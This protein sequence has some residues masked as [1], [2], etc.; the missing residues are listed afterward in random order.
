MPCSAK[1]SKRRRANANAQ[2]DRGD[3]QMAPAGTLK[4]TATTDREIVVQRAFNAPRQLV[5]DAHTKPELLKR[6]LGVHNGW[7]LDV[8]EVDLRVGGTFRYVWRGPNGE[9]MGMRGVYREIV[10][11]SRIVSTEKFDEA[12]YAGEAVGTMVLTESGGKT[13]LTLT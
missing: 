1:C 5:F 6:W 2:N 11:P 9:S 8:C 3:M 7:T 12:W 4:L 13:T 10:A